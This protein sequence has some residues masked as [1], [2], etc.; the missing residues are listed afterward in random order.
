[1]MIHPFLFDLQAD[2]N[3]SYDVRSI[4]PA[5]ASELKDQLEAFNASVRQNPRGWI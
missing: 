2:P 3:E 5:K 4:H 1:M